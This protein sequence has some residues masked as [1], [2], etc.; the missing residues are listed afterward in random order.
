MI[1][2]QKSTKN[3]TVMRMNVLQQEDAEFQEMFDLFVSNLKKLN[4]KN[5]T[6]PLLQSEMQSII[7]LF[8][9]EGVARARSDKKTRLV[10]GREEYIRNLII[11]LNAN[12][13]GSGAGEL[14]SR[15]VRLR[16]LE[17][18]F[19]SIP[20]IS[21]QSDKD[22]IL[23]RQS[24]Q[25]DLANLGL[26]WPTMNLIQS[27][28]PSLVQSAFLVLEKL[29]EGGNKTVQ[30]M[31]YQRLQNDPE[32]SFFADLSIMVRKLTTSIKL[33]RKRSNSSAMDSPQLPQEDLGMKT[34]SVIFHLF[35]HFFFNIFFFF[36]VQNLDCIC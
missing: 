30:T 28:D 14:I 21:N 27:E 17:F 33:F 1:G 15:I 4:G 26:L 23:A 31:L 12:V 10:K 8:S 16:I 22:A 7:E 11:Q 19:N 29:F 35:Q 36:F 20:N 2:T 25:T 13:G 6:I 9:E 24:A 5:S 34:L 32:N 18:M 3:S